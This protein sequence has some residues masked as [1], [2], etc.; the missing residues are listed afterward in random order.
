VPVIG[1]CI[2]SSV[3]AAEWDESIALGGGNPMKGC[4]WGPVGAIWVWCLV[5]F[6][7]IEVCKV[8]ANGVWDSTSNDG[9]ADLFMSPLSRF[10]FSKKAPTATADA[11]AAAATHSHGGEVAQ[12]ESAKLRKK[13]RATLTGENRER[14]FSLV[15]E[16]GDNLID[17][18]AVSVRK[19]DAAAVYHLAESS[20]GV[21]TTLAKMGAL[22]S[23]A[24]SKDLIAVIN[25][26][27][28][29]I[30]Q[31]EQRVSQLDGV[32]VHQKSIE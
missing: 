11:A 19:I 17:D 6:L 31:L 14:G 20:S 10:F 3:I 7:I 22:K 13:V 16:D 2:L 30:M 28:T 21:P 25:A 27:R 4:G 18:L 26:M 32:V 8:L 29:H 12:S 23:D 9:V 5:W 15:S 24:S 1:A